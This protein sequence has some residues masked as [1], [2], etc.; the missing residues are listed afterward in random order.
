V[1]RVNGLPLPTLADGAMGTMLIAAG[2]G[3]GEAPETWNV[4]PD[5]RGVVAGIHRAH[6]AAGAGV[7]LTN[8]FGGHPVRLRR[9]GA[10]SEAGELNRAAASLAREA[11]GELVP[12]AGS[13]GPT[14]ELLEPL[15]ALAFHDA[16]AGYEIQAAG[17]AA[18]GVD[19][20]WLETMA[21][22]G[23]VEAALEGARR[24]A[25]DLPIVVTMSFGSSGRTVMGVRPGD[26]ALRLS[27]LGVAAVGANCG[28]GPEEMEPVIRAMRAAVPDLPIVA[29]PNAGIP[30][31][32]DGASVYGFSPTEMG[33]AVLRLRDAG[34]T[35]V[36]GCCGTTPPHLAA[37]AARLRSVA[38]F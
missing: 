32:V 22:M 25:P 30:V 8:S 21:D 23:E 17:L 5:R 7:V 4:R 19:L 36:G 2:L 29:K 12:I 38:P 33:E 10:E 16:A 20:L 34:A 35:T 31:L 11:V 24:A 27:A 15:G 6:V 18:G 1:H 9:H 13:M 37:I 3:A 28:T 14:G 26:A